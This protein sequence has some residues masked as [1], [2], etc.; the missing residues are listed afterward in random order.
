MAD[1]SG[2]YNDLRVLEVL[3]DDRGA[4]TALRVEAVWCTA[5][6]DGPDL[7]WDRSVFTVGAV[8]S[9]AQTEVGDRLELRPVAPRPDDAG[10]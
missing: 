9:L 6:A 3:V 10:S 4:V 8:G 2:D 5:Q 1:A 7:T